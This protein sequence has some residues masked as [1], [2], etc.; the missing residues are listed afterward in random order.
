MNKE[1]E[2]TWRQLVLLPPRGSL[3]QKQTWNKRAQLALI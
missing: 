3:F 1:G 2:S